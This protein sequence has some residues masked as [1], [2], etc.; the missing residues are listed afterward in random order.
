MDADWHLNEDWQLL[1]HQYVA[2]FSIN[3][4]WFD[5]FLLFKNQ[6]GLLY[7]LFN[8]NNVHLHDII[9]H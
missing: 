6:L 8:E 7:T 3:N 2:V 5:I 9:L 1:E 4:R